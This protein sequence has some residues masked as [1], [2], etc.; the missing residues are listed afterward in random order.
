MLSFFLDNIHPFWEGIRVS[1]ELTFCALLLGILVAAG[2][3]A[4]RQERQLW[5]LNAPISVFFLFL[6]ST[7]ILVQIYLVYYGFG[8]FD[9]VRH[10]LF[11]PMLQN[12]TYCA[13]WA[14]GFNSAAY[15]S[16]IMQGALDAIPKG[17]IEAATALGFTARQRLFGLQGKRALLNLWPNY[18]NEIIMVFKATSIASTITVLELMGMTRQ[19]ISDT[20]QVT[21]CLIIAGILYLLITYSLTLVLKLI[22]YLCLPNPT[23]KRL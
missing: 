4:L 20:F 15:T 22:E 2:A 5:W 7:P 13:I 18:T 6:R 11:W 9:A 1:F 19:L 14:L 3:V 17:E 12:P 10:S 16:V 23:T 21:D 8:Q